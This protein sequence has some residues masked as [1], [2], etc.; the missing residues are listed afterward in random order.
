MCSTIF[1]IHQRLI[2]PVGYKC[3]S[4]CSFNSSGR[5]I[6]LY[7][8]DWSITMKTFC[9]RHCRIAFIIQESTSSL[10]RG[11][12]MA[13]LLCVKCPSGSDVICHWPLRG[14]GQVAFTAAQRV[15]G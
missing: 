4:L 12:K 15:F 7:T 8:S 10:A 13:E 14:D 3:V 1:I 5:T 9:E 6:L 11:E 2:A